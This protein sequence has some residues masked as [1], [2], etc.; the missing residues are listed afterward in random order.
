MDISH[1][2]ITSSTS[3]KKLR[4]F[5]FV[6]VLLITLSFAAYTHHAWEDYYITYRVSKNLATGNGLVFTIGE[7]VHVFTSPFNVLVPAAL[8]FIT[9]NTSDALV[10]WLFRILC[11]SLLAIAAILLFNTARKNSLTLIPSAVLLGMFALD[12]KIVD[13]TINGQEIAFMM[14]FLAL[15][16][17]A[18]TLR[19]RW[20]IV[21][22]ALAWA[23]LM[24]TRP[25]GFIYIAAIAAGFLIFNAGGAI[26]QNRKGLLKIYLYAGAIS[27][28]LYLPWLLWA[29]HYYGS[30][31]P[32]T[33]SAKGYTFN[34]FSTGF[35]TLFLNFITFPLRLL[36]GGT[37]IDQTFLPIYA[38]SFGGWHYSVYVFSRYLSI[39]CALYWCLPFGRP[40]ARAVSFAFMTCNFYL[41][42]IAAYPAPW[43][44]PSC[45]I[46]AIF[47][48]AHFLQQCLNL[49]SLL[50]DKD[51]KIFR[52][53]II[54]FRASAISILLITLSLLLCSAYQLR[55]QQR[56]I[57]TGNRMQIGLWLKDN[58]AST[59]DTVFLEPLGYIGYFSQLKML[60]FPGLSAPE[61]VAAQKKLKSNLWVKLIPELRPDWLVLR[62]TEAGPIQKADPL[63]LT[64]LY[65][66][67]KV[68]DVSERLKAYRWLPGREYLAYDQTF[69]VFKRN[70]DQTQESN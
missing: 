43:Y 48:F 61:V 24:W 23:G 51:Y 53:S 55:I 6:G 16:L 70:K 63:L 22:I 25:D 44:I 30:P 38:S 46:L 50:K 67:A 66:V 52:Q 11:A 64:Q 47:V 3:D 31:I 27:I 17:N 29:W 62:P 56:E 59:S 10:L 68:F 4:L 42:H 36:L 49:V 20:S 65:S 58:A 35:G 34:S 54:F 33:I 18:L 26:A 37:S 9:A 13:Y 1:N 28:A 57:E 32:H 69:I 21:K 5:I 40:Q 14:F 60:D 2:L 45:T 41:T 7:K 8:S 15:M 39:L 19:S 12:T